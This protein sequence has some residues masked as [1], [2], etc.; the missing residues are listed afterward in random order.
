MDEAYHYPP[1][2]LEL[3][4]ETIPRLCPSK[5]SVLAFLRG[6]GV[7]HD[8]LRDLA[9]QV[10]KDRSKITK[11][12]IV[13][14]VLTRLNESGDARLRERREIVKRVVEFEDFSTCWPADQLKATGR[15]VRRSIAISVAWRAG[16]VSASITTAEPSRSSESRLPTLASGRETVTVTLALGGS[17]PCAAGE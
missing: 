7:Q 10:A 8:V 15:P 16:I 12:A 3:L 1:E 6:A 14:A 2:L 13:R 5:P 11:F 17:P 4:V 9:Q